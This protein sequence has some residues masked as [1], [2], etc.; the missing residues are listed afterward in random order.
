M[1]YYQ[2]GVDIVG[3]PLFAIHVISEKENKYFN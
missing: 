2:I 1:I 3:Q